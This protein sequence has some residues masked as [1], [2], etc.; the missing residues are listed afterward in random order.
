MKRKSEI[1]LDNRRPKKVKVDIWKQIEEKL[2][3][4]T[5]KQ[6]EHVIWE[7]KMSKHGGWLTMSFDKKIKPIFDW[8]Y[9]WSTKTIDPNPS[10]SR[11]KKICDEKNCLS[12]FILTTQKLTSVTEMSPDDYIN[13]CEQINQN[14]EWSDLPTGNP[15][16]K[17]KC[18]LWTAAKMGNYGSM[19]A[20]G[21]T[22]YVTRIVLQLVLFQDIPTNIVARHKCLNKL[23]INEDHLEL[24]TQKDNNKD[25]QRDGT[26]KFGESSHLST[27]T[28]G[29][30]KKIFWS[31]SPEKS[32]KQRA[33]EFGVSE[34]IVHSI[35][36]GETWRHLFTDS[37][38]LKVHQITKRSSPL[39][40]D[41]IQKILRH[42]QDGLSILECS[43]IMN[44]GKWR[45]RNIYNKKTFQKEKSV[46]Q[47]TSTLIR[48]TFTQQEIDKI[49]DR[50][51][52][53]IT[54]Q[55]S[56]QGIHWIWKRCHDKGYGRT[57][58]KS[59]SLLAHR[60]SFFVFTD[61]KQLTPIDFIRHK[62]RETA[63]VNPDHLEIGS[64]KQN[65]EDRIR[66][67][68]HPIGE[69]NPNASISDK[70]AKEIKNSKGLGSA[71]ERAKH[72]S[73]SYNIVINIDNGIAWT[74]V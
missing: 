68:T 28:D 14:S 33:I 57:S 10:K 30:A 70:L 16:L 21:S 13:I 40:N 24:G 43:K 1:D 71:R 20:F 4:Q 39:T 44:M 17:T 62:C 51:L 19:K 55:K 5:K 31:Q 35:D 60:V 7:G 53:N 37:D 72:F 49:R 32:R 29:L 64:A 47:K 8:Y 59:C 23:C 36:T 6:G 69:K 25:K 48:S 54:E 45:I 3:S 26:H 11:Y 41:Q 52:D 27:I 67:G 61:C 22:S 50:I 65:S 63:C 56:D 12:H 73:V 9:R 66:D 2:L 74:H 42:Q 46:P 15:E 58:I 38:R 18:R 34:R